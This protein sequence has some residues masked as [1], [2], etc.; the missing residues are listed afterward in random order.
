[1]VPSEGD[2]QDVNEGTVFKGVSKVKG[3]QTGNTLGQAMTRSAP[4][5]QGWSKRKSCEQNQEELTRRQGSL[6]DTLQE[7]SHWQPDLHTIGAR[8][9]PPK[10]PL[11]GPLTSENIYP[12]GMRKMTV[13]SS[14]SHCYQALY[15]NAK[16]HVLEEILLENQSRQKVKENNILQDMVTYMTRK[17]WESSLSLLTQ[18]EMI[19]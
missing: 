4:T 3:N 13:G 16:P 7:G 19:R 1:M 2:Y 15:S 6:A 14:T 9:K 17:Y 8:A 18:R 11:L 5:P 12:R 10:L